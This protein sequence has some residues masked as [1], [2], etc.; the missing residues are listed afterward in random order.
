M[1]EREEKMMKRILCALLA[2]VLTL[3]LFACS[4]GEGNGQNE[5]NGGEI[6]D[7]NGQ[8]VNICISVN[9]YKEVTFPA[10]DIYT[11]GPDEASSNEVAKEVLARNARAEEELGIEI[12]YSTRDIAWDGIQEDIRTIVQ[13]ASKESPDI[14]NN[15]SYGLARAMVDGMLWNVKDPGEDVTNYFNFDAEG[16]YHE[17]M[18]GCTFN[19]D[20]FYLLASDYFIDMIRMA[21]VVL[22]NHD[23]FTANSAAMPTWCKTL[24]DFYASV[25]A[26]FW[27]MDALATLSNAVFTEGAGG[28]VGVTDKTDETLGFAY[29]NNSN[30]VFCAASGVTVY[31]Q[32][33]EDGYKPKVMESIDT[34]QKVSDA[35][36]ALTEAS[37]VYYEHDTIVPTNCFLQ[38][39]FLFA[40]S[41]L[42]EMESSELRNFKGNKGLVPVPKWDSREQEEYHTIL[43]DQVEIGC[44]LNTAKTFSASSALMQFMAEESGDVVYTYYEKGLKYKYNDDKN[45]RAMM[46]LVRETTDSPFGFQIGVICQTLYTGSPA[47]TGLYIKNNSTIASTF[48]SEKDAYRSCMAQ[49]IEKFNTIP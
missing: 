19:Q 47:L 34:Y 9:K 38:G 23:I 41:R 24:D 12:E 17:F 26:G 6:V 40:I 28:T 33:K 1:I 35:F 18:K 22:V 27:D 48:A 8:K 14:Y 16:W 46:D 31:Y 36:K 43:H 15:D 3:G 37:G 5:D 7:F 21:W 42:G 20:K 32:D 39:N 29:C 11:K 10:A 49:M 4:G 13:T 2:L 30:W 44:I 45:A 25:D